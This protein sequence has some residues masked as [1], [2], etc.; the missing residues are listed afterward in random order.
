MK[1]RVYE[2]KIVK[3]NIK[4]NNNKFWSCEVYSDGLLIRRW[5]LKLHN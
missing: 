2:S 1:E 5:G 4:E 3:V